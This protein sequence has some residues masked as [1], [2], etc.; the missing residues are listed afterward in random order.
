MSLGATLVFMP[1]TRR[2]LS[3][4]VR[5]EQILETASVLFSEQGFENIKMADIAEKLETS[6]PNIYTYYPSTEAILDTLLERVVGEYV[7]EMRQMLTENPGSDAVDTFEVLMRHREMLMLLHSGGG[8]KFRE[9]RRKVND[10]LDELTST[11]MAN[12]VS[13]DQ[14]RKAMRLMLITQRTAVL[15]MAYELLAEGEEWDTKQVGQV[16]DAMLRAAYGQVFPGI[17]EEMI[18]RG[19]KPRS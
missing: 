12:L 15:G 9:R 10:S 5:R 18:K 17:D 4:D 6:R 11:Y 8:S 13:D 16:I 3:A 1:G 19:V 14:K 2:R 7:S